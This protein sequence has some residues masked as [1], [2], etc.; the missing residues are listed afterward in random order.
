MDEWS[1]HGVQIYWMETDSVTQWVAFSMDLITDYS[2]EV[3]CYSSYPILKQQLC[4]LKPHKW[5]QN[6]LNF[7]CSWRAH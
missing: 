7:I 2:S 4:A 3:L 6:I 5:V 1:V